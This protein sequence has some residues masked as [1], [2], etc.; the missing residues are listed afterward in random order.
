MMTM[1]FYSHCLNFPLVLSKKNL[2]HDL[3]QTAM[4]KK[5]DLP[6]KGKVAVRSEDVGY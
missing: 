5:I 6:D 1:S 3:D 2:D 4:M